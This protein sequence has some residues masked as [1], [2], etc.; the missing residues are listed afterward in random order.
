ML[1]PVLRSHALLALLLLGGCGGD[2]AP[3]EEEVMRPTAGAI[4]V[5]HL[6]TGEL[7]AV[8]NVEVVVP[9]TLELTLQISWLA[10]DGTEVAAGD[11][12]LEFDNAAFADS[13][14]EKRISRF[15]ARQALAEERARADERLIEA[16]LAVERTRIALA[17]AC[18]AA[19][20]PA[21]I[22]SELDA[23]RRRLAFE[24]ALT[25]HAK[26]SENLAVA[27]ET[28]AAE[29]RVREIDLARVEEAVAVA[30]RTVDE[31]VITAPVAGI[32]VVA[33]HPWEERKLQVGDT[34]WAGLP[35]IRLPDLSRMRVVASLFDV[36]DGAVAIGE[37]VRCTLDTYPDLV[38][39]GT[40][41]DLT[42]VA[43][44]MGFM[45]L[46]RAFRVIVELER[47]DSARM[48]PGMSVLVDAVR[49]VADHCLLVPRRALDLDGA[50][51]RARLASGGWVEVTLG[52]CS[53]QD[54][55]VLAG[56]DAA[57]ELG[58]ATG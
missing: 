46:R 39:A 14:D 25:E 13:L 22:I 2:P 10:E 17:S 51:A 41:A 5:R 3:T 29:V 55:E 34:P 24:R 36:D 9:K 11:R 44:E 57:T 12:V 42:P 53:A 4:A 38:V 27:E 1:Q 6:V 43:Q 52:A 30:E 45:S 26:S 47:T 15:E 32:V 16:R 19:E 54:C 20:I 33:D 40:V 18:L 58:A 21:S 7:E 50:T 8:A 28:A 48:R 23:S 35:V 56:I 49:P 37:S 31:L